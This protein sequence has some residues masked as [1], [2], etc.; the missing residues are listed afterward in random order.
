[1]SLCSLMNNSPFLRLAAGGGGCVTQFDLRNAER[2]YP[3]VQSGGAI[4]CFAR[5]NTTEWPIFG[6]GKLVLFTLE[7]FEIHTPAPQIKAPYLHLWQGACAIG[8]TLLPKAQKAI[9]ARGRLL[10]LGA[11]RKHKPGHQHLYL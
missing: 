11:L 5:F 1:M 2:A 9:P 7:W 10:G 4:L 8:S 3:D 6:T